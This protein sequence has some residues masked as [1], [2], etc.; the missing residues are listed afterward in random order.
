M[1]S[2]SEMLGRDGNI[3]KDEHTKIQPYWR[4]VPWRKFSVYPNI[5]S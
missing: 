4:K 3:P 2:P 1:K 5:L